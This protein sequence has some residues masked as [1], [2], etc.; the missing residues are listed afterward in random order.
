M[1]RPPQAPVLDLS[2]LSDSVVPVRIEGET[3]VPHGST[4]GTSWC[5]SRIKLA[6]SDPD[7]EKLRV[8]HEHKQDVRTWFGVAT[9]TE[10][11]YGLFHND[12]HHTVEFVL[13]YTETPWGNE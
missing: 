13:R 10:A 3:V 8:A 12:E 6:G 7:S 5:E 1:S 9:I 4:Y 11:N 2:H